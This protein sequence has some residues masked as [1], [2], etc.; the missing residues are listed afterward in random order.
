MSNSTVTLTSSLV[1]SSV[2]LSIFIPFI[3]MPLGGGLRWASDVVIIGQF[4]LS[5]F[6]VAVTINYKIS[7]VSLSVFFLL[8]IVMMIPVL[9]GNQIDVVAGA[10][11]LIPLITITALFIGRHQIPTQIL[12]VGIALCLIL[13]LGWTLLKP[14]YF[15]ES[16]FF[17]NAAT[18][19]ARF[20]PFFERSPHSSG[21]MVAAAVMVL[22]ASRPLNRP[23]I[24]LHLL[25]LAGLVAGAVLIVGY[26]S[27]QVIMTFLVFGGTWL[28]VSG[29]IKVSWKYI[30]RL[31]VVLVAAYIIYD[32]II[33]N[34]SLRGSWEIDWRL[35]GS[36]RV[37]TWF[38]RYELFIERPVWQIWFGSGAGSDYILGAVWTYATAAHNMII[39]YTMEFGLFGLNLFIIYFWIMY[40]S[41]NRASVA[42]M[43]TVIISGLIGNGISVRPTVFILFAAASAIALRR[44]ECQAM[45]NMPARNVYI[46][47]PA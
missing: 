37:G 4:V 9:A 34:M 41:L 20:Y 43:T 2:V 44:R 36:G 47:K 31:F 40:R 38:G 13:L 18:R 15:H 30:I 29:T 45:L 16:E 5:F 3:V 46:K 11:L 33:Y 12:Y 19:R 35:L 39:T 1:G 24:W 8:S 28:M 10:K 32:K 25:W 26:R 14:A 17:A 27:S 22:F 42:L 23:R 21:Y 6:L 7:F